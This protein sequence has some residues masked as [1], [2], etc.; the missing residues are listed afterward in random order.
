MK[1]GC[2]DA[3]KEHLKSCF[4]R[5]RKRLNLSQVGFARKLEVDVRSYIALE[6]GD[7]L[8]STTTFLRFLF[9]CCADPVGLLEELE[10][11]INDGQTTES[12]R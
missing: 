9:T 12:S 2:R 1:Q 8:C 4:L 11:I 6:H 5:E 3:I 7:Y 10:E